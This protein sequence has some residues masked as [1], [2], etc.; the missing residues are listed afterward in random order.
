LTLEIVNFPCDCGRRLKARR[1]DAGAEIDC[2][3]CGRVLIIPA[4]DTDVP[5]RAPSAA[6][7]DLADG[8]LTQASVPWPDAG[9]RRRGADGP[10]PRDE[11]VGSWLPTV[12]IVLLVQV[13]GGVL[14]YFMPDIAAYSR[15]KERAFDGSAPLLAEAAAGHRSGTD[16]DYIPSSALAFLTFRPADLEPIAAG[17]G[18]R[19]ITL[20]KTARDACERLAGLPALQVERLTFVTLF[21]TRDPQAQAKKGRESWLLVST[22]GTPL[23]K[24]VL[25][26]LIPGAIPKT[27]KG[28]QYFVS[29]TGPRAPK[30]PP[31][32]V[33][34]VGAKLYVITDPDTMKRFFRHAPRA[35]VG[36][37][38]E[39]AKA[40]KARHHLVIGLNQT[41]FLLRPF[42]VAPPPDLPD[43]Q[44][45]LVTADEPASVR[46]D[47]RLDY[48]KPA[49]A[50]K[51]HAANERQVGM[52][53]AVVAAEQSQ[54]AR[55]RLTRREAP[56]C[57]TI[58]SL[59]LS[60]LSPLGPLHVV[61]GLPAPQPTVQE[62]NLEK[63]LEIEELL[64]RAQLKLAD[65]SLQISLPDEPNLEA[66]SWI[67]LPY[68]VLARDSAAVR[69]PSP[70]EVK[71]GPKGRR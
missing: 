64:L 3:D 53:T 33:H 25:Q 40:V 15:E 35:P 24:V 29:P 23:K 43:F 5:P 11:K 30:G 63:R 62:T 32:A 4:A 69:R 60:V 42:G 68:T 2:P 54:L 50:A 57:R 67:W 38:G 58:G 36:P 46:V 37:L 55:W 8:L 41:A 18:T 52:L 39:A 9:T 19:G 21:P 65:R 17:Q 22:T 31:K 7:A 28:H 20:A 71:G 6:G 10:E 44:S 34:F 14:W 12:A 47:I 48:D 16:L 56:V 61:P 26:Q 13:G 59:A 49:T 45:G 51:A 1:R 27:F 66:A 70:L